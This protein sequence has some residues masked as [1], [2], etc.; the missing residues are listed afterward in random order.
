MRRPVLPIAAVLA[1]V[2]ALTLAGAALAIRPPGVPDDAGDMRQA[3][4]RALVA[5]FYDAANAAIATGD[6]APLATLL[7]PGFVE[8]GSDS[9]EESGRDGLIRRLLAIHAAAPDVR[10]AVAA[11]AADGDLV[12]A[13]VR[14]SDPDPATFLGLRL[15]AAW[16]PWGPIDVFRTR[17]G[18]IVERSGPV[19]DPAPA[20]PDFRVALDVPAPE[21]RSLSVARV[22]LQA[23]ARYEAAGQSGP[24][25]VFV[26]TGAI[27]VEVVPIAASA[28]PATILAAGDHLRLPVNAGFVVQNTGSSS[29]VLVE[30][31]LA[32][33]PFAERASPPMAPSPP[34]GGTVQTL[35]ADLL[36]ALPA[37]STVLSI[38]R[39]TLQPGERLGWAAAAGPVLLHVEAGTVDLA[40]TGSVPWVQGVAQERTAAGVE[41]VLDRGGG[42]LLEAG[43]TVEVHAAPNIPATLLVVTLMAG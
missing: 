35:A 37:Q 11:M 3:A 24:R 43:G 23:G 25:V 22:T 16:T 5:S 32:A 12:I 27:A 17:D 14:V 9:G 1:A 38:G 29:A 13:H 18:R 40:A 7:D 8:R 15:D 36:I 42:V 31:A 2:T 39:M 26:E 41:A 30:V 6:A 19:G 34:S 10:L 33:R 28:T 4:N 21:M 20:T